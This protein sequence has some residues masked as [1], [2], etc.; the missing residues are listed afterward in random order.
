[1]KGVN[2]NSIKQAQWKKPR[3]GKPDGILNNR[4]YWRPE[5]VREWIMQT[6]L[7]LK[8]LYKR[9]EEEKDYDSHQ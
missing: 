6:D 1:M 8:Q 4:Y 3:G 2:Y 7:Q 5:T 9:E